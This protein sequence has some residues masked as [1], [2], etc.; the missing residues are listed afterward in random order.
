M[1]G[2]RISPASSNPARYDMN[3]RRIS[4]GVGNASN[5]HS[6]VYGNRGVSPT[7][8]QKNDSVERKQP[9]RSS[10][11]GGKWDIYGRVKSKERS[12]S[13]NNRDPY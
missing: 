11:A 9:N 7:G 5:P 6:R 4:P 12:G 3:G 1:N 2:R 10:G 13:N 8:Q